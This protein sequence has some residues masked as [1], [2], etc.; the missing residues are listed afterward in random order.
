MDEEQEHARVPRPW[1]EL[2][3]DAPFLL[4]W[5]ELHTHWRGIFRH[6]SSELPDDSPIVLLAHPGVETLLGSGEA[7]AWLEAWRATHK[8][9]LP[10][11]AALDVSHAEIQVASPPN[12]IVPNRTYSKKGPSYAHLRT[13][14]SSF[15]D[16]ALDLDAHGATT[17]R[18]R[19]L[20]RTG[21]R[22]KGAHMKESA[23]NA[24]I[25]I[26]DDEAE[27]IQGSSSSPMKSQKAEREVIDLTE[28]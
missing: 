3:R 26:S 12:R 15:A 18:A 25:N 21:R 19:A 1:L 5:H 11:S 13:R 24:V 2:L 7:I 6:Q 16:N 4:I 27:F 22:A 17:P 9:A 8:L 23:L 20:T 10:K 28:A 14:A